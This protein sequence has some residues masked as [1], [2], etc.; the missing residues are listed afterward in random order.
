MFYF[1]LHLEMYYTNVKYSTQREYFKE[2]YLF[3]IS[4]KTAS[5]VTT[6]L[7]LC[8]CIPRNQKQPNDHDVSKL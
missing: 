5:S 6:Y 3:W 4:H 2:M 1:N 8:T 7:H